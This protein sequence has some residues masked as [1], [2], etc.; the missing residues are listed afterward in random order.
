MYPSAMTGDT[1]LRGAGQ[2]AA[3][4]G[5]VASAADDAF[6][7]LRERMIRGEIAPGEMLS[8]NELAAE[9]GVSRTPI[10]QALIRL[11][12]EDW[13]TIYPKRGALVLDISPREARAI[14]DAAVLLE[15]DGV[16]RA[17]PD[18]L[19]ALAPELGDLVCRHEAALAAGDV[20][21][22]VRLTLLFH[23]GFVEVGDNPVLLAM[24]DRLRHRKAM[25]LIRDRDEILP[26]AAE[27]VAEHRALVVLARAGDAEGFRL[28]LAEHVT[29]THGT[30]LAKHG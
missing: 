30:R 14:A 15:S 20:E 8:E 17:N 18:A 12:D 13:L 11:Q 25:M 4:P 29:R 7:R 27:I 3:A 19:L 22:F 1:Q 2:T 5:G 28:A 10:R 26:R 24:Y 16:R 23:R 9:L 6:L 21:L